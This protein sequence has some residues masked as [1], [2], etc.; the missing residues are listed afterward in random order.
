[1][2][3]GRLRHR[4]TIERRG[5]TRDDGGQEIETW[6]VISPEGGLPA[7]IRPLSGRELLLAQQV[8]AEINTEIELRYF[9]GVTARDRA[10]HGA[11]IY[12]IK[13]T[14]VPRMLRRTLILRCGTGLNNG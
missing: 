14:I 13:E 11:T 5:T 1:M 12:D 7:D 2:R 8:N 4:V 6:T 3:A 10:V 9:D